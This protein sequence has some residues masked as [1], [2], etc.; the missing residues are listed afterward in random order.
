MTLQHTYVHQEPV[1]SDAGQMHAASAPLP[2][3]GLARVI[4]HDVWYACEQ[5][6]DDRNVPSAKV[7]MSAMHDFH[8]G[9]DN[10]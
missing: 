1:K 8:A 3:L 6:S 2:L 7:A 5:L 4:M 10:T 9:M